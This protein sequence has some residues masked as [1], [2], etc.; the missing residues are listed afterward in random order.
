MLN[1]ITEMEEVVSV[2]RSHPRKHVMH[3]TR[4]WEFVG[5]EEAEMRQQLSMD[6][7][8][9]ANNQDLLTRADY[10]RNVIVG[11]IDSGE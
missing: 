4:S 8:R 3:T 2:F 7:N 5:L 10:G 9:V 6:K 1:L 11:L